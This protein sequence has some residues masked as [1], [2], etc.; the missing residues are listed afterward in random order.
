[1]RHWRVTLSITFSSRIL[2]LCLE[3]G[4]AEAFFQRIKV[5]QHLGKYFL[6]DAQFLSEV[7][8]IVCG[9]TDERLRGD[10]YAGISQLS[11]NHADTLLYLG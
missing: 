5:S 2:F 3:C 1:M 11:L 4:V 6:R 9:G 7:S 10:I 8:D